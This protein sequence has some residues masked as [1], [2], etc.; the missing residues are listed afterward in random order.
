MNTYRHGVRHKP[1]LV[2]LHKEALQRVLLWGTLIGL[3]GQILPPLRRQQRLIQEGPT[4]ISKSV[5]EVGF[6]YLHAETFC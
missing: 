3:H 4:Q 5:L 1:T 6:T 2:G